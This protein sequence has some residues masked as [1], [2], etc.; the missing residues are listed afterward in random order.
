MLIGDS[1]G[2]TTVLSSSSVVL[3]IKEK[4]KKIVFN[5]H[6]HSSTNSSSNVDVTTFSNTDC[7]SSSP[8]VSHENPA[9]EKPKKPIY[10]LETP[11]YTLQCI[12]ENEMPKAIEILRYWM[13]SCQ[14]QEATEDCM[15][16]IWELKQENAVYTLNE[17]K[18]CQRFVWGT[19]GKDMKLSSTIESTLSG[20]QLSTLGL[21]DSDTTGRCINC[22]YVIVHK[23]ET[24]KLPIG[25][26]AKH[27]E[28]AVVNLGKTDFFLGIDWLQHHNPSIDWEQ[29][30]LTDVQ[31]NVD[32]F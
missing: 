8:Y 29:S 10:K 32:T 3:D 17:L 9:P 22:E 30:T 14:C 25:D 16:K 15:T 27:I 4:N 21:V 6:T 24:K 20:V 19:K 31:N 23:L 5:N 7:L 18:K 1:H 11:K 26:Y 12:A 2:F 13:P 28:M